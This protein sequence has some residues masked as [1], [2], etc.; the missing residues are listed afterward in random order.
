MQCMIIQRM[1][2][3]LQKGREVLIFPPLHLDPEATLEQAWE[4]FLPMLA[5]S[6]EPLSPVIE[7]IS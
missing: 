4:S 6:S 1:H 7:L 2:D 3:A 5:V